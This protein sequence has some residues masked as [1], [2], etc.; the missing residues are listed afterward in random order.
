MRHR[1]HELAERLEE[2]LEALHGPE[3]E[4]AACALRSYGAAAIPVLEEHFRCESRGRRRQA[5]LHT[6]CELRDPRA[7]PTLADA[8]R[9]PNERV[10][11]EA[12]DGLVTLA[13]PRARR[14]LEDARASLPGDRKSATKR[15]W[16]EEAIEQVREAWRP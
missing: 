3:S 10:W 2:L 11:K 13:G 4:G 9:D 12:L 1:P 14:I 15:E 16:I 7:F 8:L 5:I 6:L